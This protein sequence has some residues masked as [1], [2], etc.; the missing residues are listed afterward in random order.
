MRA[1]YGTWSG[2]VLGC[3]IF[4]GMGGA[5]WAQ[6]VDANNSV[7]YRVNYRPTDSAPWQLYS[8]T[9]SK[10]KAEATAADVRKSGYLAEVVDNSTPA[11]QPFPDAADTSASDYY[12]TSN[13]TNDYNYY[14]VPGG[15]YNYGWYGGW[16]PGFGYR[17]GPWYRT[18]GGRYWQHGYW[19]GYGY[20]AGWGRSWGGGD[21]WNGSHRNWNYNHG[22][23]SS[24][25]S[26][27]ERHANNEHHGYAQHRATAGHQ[28]AGHHA[29]GARAGNAMAEH[30]GTGHF[31]GGNRNGAH[32]TGGHAARG[33]HPSP[34]RQAAGHHAAHMDP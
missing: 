16:Y 26:N 10:D 31:G 9:R 15:G 24:H 2:L 8:E 34:G 33:G 19:R 7:R 14:Q 28:T 17:M 23:R 20:N 5:A 21:S 13:Y 3:L 30:R 29:A 4:C 25:L 12:P 18:N 11:P 6:D 32:H 27:F 1:R 22:S